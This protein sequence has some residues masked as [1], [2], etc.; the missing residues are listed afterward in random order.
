M[1]NASGIDVVGSK[2]VKQAEVVLGE[3]WVGPDAKVESELRAK[4]EQRGLV[5][6]NRS[7]LARKIITFNLLA[8]LVLVAGVLMLNP[9][10]D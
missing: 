9:F 8:I 7:P 3:D 10:R 5:S 1:N 4:R 6:I 2:P